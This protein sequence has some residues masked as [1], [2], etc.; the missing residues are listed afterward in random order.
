MRIRFGPP[1][2]T[3]GLALA[4]IVLVALAARA[5]TFAIAV[6]PPTGPY[7]VGTSSMRMVDL[8]RNDPYVA[9]GSKRE[10]LIR[11]WYP[12]SLVQGYQ[13]AD[14]ASPKVWRYISQLTGVDLPSI[15]TNSL[16]NAPMASGP[17]PV[18][19]LTHGYT[20]TLTDYTFLT[21]DLASRGYVVVSVAHTYESTAVEFPDG[22]LVQSVLG[23]H[24]RL[25]ALR[26]DEQSL[27]FAAHVRLQDLSSVLDELRRLNST[28]GN[29]LAAQLDLRHI[30]VMGHSLGGT[31]ALAGVAWEPR[32]AAAI[33]MDAPVITAS[34]MGTDKPV[35][36]VAAG[37]D[38]W[39]TLDC[40][41]WR[42]LRGTRLLVHLRGA[43]HLTA[44]DAV[45][46]AKDFPQLEAETGA[47]GAEKTIA[48][49]RN[50]IASFLDNVL[51]GKAKGAL[52]VGPSPDYPDV[53]LTTE[54]Q[55]LCGELVKNRLP[56]SK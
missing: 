49:M 32:F 42:R 2:Y 56:S 46:L 24:F 28:R 51:L 21:E 11:L 50:Y 45:W 53:A 15:Q 6:P 27:S 9:N 18:V 26:T 14:Y 7:K 55:S 22:R 30:A 25:D 34:V 40:Q 13:H 31:A 44:S 10:L 23:S 43:E 33:V 36:I 47:M 35:L 54:K 38:Q 1:L 39:G 20:G 29:L 48:A 16:L 5:E 4:T 52:L 17:H 8:R 41:L 19:L 3:F 37:R 12:A